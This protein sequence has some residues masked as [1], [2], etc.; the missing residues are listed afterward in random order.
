MQKGPLERRIHSPNI[1][2]DLQKYREFTKPAWAQEVSL[3]QRS[4]F[5]GNKSLETKQPTYPKHNHNNPIA[6]F[7]EIQEKQDVNNNMKPLNPSL[8]YDKS[9]VKT[10]I[11]MLSDTIDTSTPCNLT[12]SF[13]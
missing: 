8:G 9:R 2:A 12:I 7:K 3:E 1:F 11:T 5:L 6:K 10:G 4:K 13:I